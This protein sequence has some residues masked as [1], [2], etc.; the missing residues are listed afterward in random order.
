MGGGEASRRI[1]QR[2]EEGWFVQRKMR[3]GEGVGGRKNN[4]M[5]QTSLPYV[6]V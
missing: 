4:R 1:I 2:E 3:G 5:R 6:H